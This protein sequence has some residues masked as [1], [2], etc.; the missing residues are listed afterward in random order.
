MKDQE[1]CLVRH[2]TQTATIRLFIVKF[3]LSIE[4]TPPPYDMLAWDYE[5]V[6]SENT[7]KSMEMVNWE[8][9]FTNKKYLENNM[10]IKVLFSGFSNFIPNKNIIFE[11][12]ELHWVN[13]LVKRKIRWKNAI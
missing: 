13:E 3:S 12:K 5:K 2:L 10:F 6:N 11:D 7:R 4:Y 1:I 8:T 9:M